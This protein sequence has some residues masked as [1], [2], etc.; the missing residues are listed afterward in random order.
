MFVSFCI[1]L[2]CL[3]AVLFMA[4]QWAR[5]KK[6]DAETLNNESTEGLIGLDAFADRPIVN[7]HNSDFESGNNLWCMLEQDTYL[8]NAY[9]RCTDSVKLKLNKRGNLP[10]ASMILENG[11]IFFID[12]MMNIVPDNFKNIGPDVPTLRGAFSNGRFNFTGIV[13][14]MAILSELNESGRNYIKTMVSEIYYDNINNCFSLN[15]ASTAASVILGDIN[16]LG[17]KIDKLDAYFKSNPYSLTFPPESIDLRWSNH[18]VTSS[19]ELTA[20][21]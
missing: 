18:I 9:A 15:L 6:P 4:S 8:R 17:Y 5:D 21:K 1:L 7:M 14:C 3:S 16:G 12:S 11:H 2:I 19:N 20:A 10:V 13:G